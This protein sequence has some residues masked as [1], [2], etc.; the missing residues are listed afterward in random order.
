M[1]LA[2]LDTKEWR[3]LPRYQCIVFGRYPVR[4]WPLGPFDWPCVSSPLLFLLTLLSYTSYNAYLTLFNGLVQCLAVYILY[5]PFLGRSS[6]QP[7]KIH[8]LLRKIQGEN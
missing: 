6:L 4:V 5:K 7:S 1:P 8:R 3:P 2:R